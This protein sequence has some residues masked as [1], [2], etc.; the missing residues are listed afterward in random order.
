[1][2]HKL[3]TLAVGALIILSSTSAAL[4][5]VRITIQQGRVTV[6]A[7]DATV[8]QILAEWARVGQT[9]VVNV[10][11]IPGGPLTLELTDVPEQQALDI[12]LRAV[13][14]YLA[15]PRAVPVANASV[16]DRIVV[17]PTS[18]A[19]AAPLGAQ[20]PP[21]AQSGAQ[22]PRPLFDDDQDDDRPLPP[23]PG[24]GRPPIF[25][26]PPPPIANG[27]NGPM[28]IPAMI[29]PSGQQVFPPP[30]AGPGGPPPTAARPGAPTTPTPVGTAAPGMAMPTPAPQP[31]QPVSIFP[32][33]PQ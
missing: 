11:R 20:P 29:G 16:F 33:Q 7:Q 31:G 19:A 23:V 9:N 24:Q 1:M 2:P 27:P 30:P 22:S 3:A 25:S 18:V 5:E 17:M 12:L 14:G 4:A 6:V 32:G 15:A 28:N 21:S 10:D 13:S 8:R 26:I